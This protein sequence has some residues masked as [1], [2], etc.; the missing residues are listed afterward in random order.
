[1]KREKISNEIAN[2]GKKIIIEIVSMLIG[3]IKSNSD[4]VYENDFEY[5]SSNNSGSLNT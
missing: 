4:R 3:L 5:K 2:E 1:M